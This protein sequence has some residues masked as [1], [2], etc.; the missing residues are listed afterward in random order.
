MIKFKAFIF[1]FDGTLAD[2]LDDLASAVNYAMS[3][4]N[5]PI[6]SIDQVRQRIGFGIDRLVVD[7]LPEKYRSNKKIVG[8]SLELMAG[9]YAEHWKDNARL[10]G[11]VAEML[12]DLALNKI[13]MAILSNK[14]E[15]FL[16]EFV[17]FLVPKWDFN[18]VIGG[19]TNYPLKP[20]PTSTIEII[21][22]FKLE[23]KD[24]AFVGDG[25]TDIHTAI[26]AG[27]TPIAV[28]WGYRSKKE[29]AE[30]GATIFIDSAKELLSYI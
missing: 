27:V 26:A 5:F 6:L 23:K 25:D 14:P 15:A 3:S 12:D 2:S 21:K 16:K 1:D 9:Y 13:P 24:I 19:R 10:F 7:T 17:E 4:Q 11:G 22:S 29:L 30:V 8:R 18:M 28:T 20:N